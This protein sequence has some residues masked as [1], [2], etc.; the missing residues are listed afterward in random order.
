MNVVNDISFYL[1]DNDYIRNKDLGGEV[2][3]HTMSMLIHHSSQVLMIPT[4]KKDHKTT[5]LFVVITNMNLI[6]TTRY[7]FFE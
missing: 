2:A 5:Y 7:V 3:I 1:L 6:V 4:V